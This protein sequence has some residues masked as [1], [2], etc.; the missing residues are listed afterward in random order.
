MPLDAPAAVQTKLVRA[1]ET[2][3]SLWRAPCAAVE[4]HVRAS[5]ERSRGAVVDGVNTVVLQ[6]RLWCRRGRRSGPC[7][8]Q[9]ELAITTVFN[10]SGPAGRGEIVEADIELNGVHHA[11][12]AESE[13]PALPVPSVTVLAHELG[14]VLGFDHP[15]ENGTAPSSIM[16]QTVHD[17]LAGP[18]GPTPADLEALCRAYPDPPRPQDPPSTLLAHSQPR[19]HG[20]GSALAALLAGCVGVVSISW[21]VRAHRRSVDTHRHERRL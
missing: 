11:W 15:Q 2:A 13:H 18:E 20:P 12:F 1:L 19:E 21:F 10:G 5:A 14:H 7:Y 9:E 6:Q 17:G 3:A 8:R 16:S 4:I